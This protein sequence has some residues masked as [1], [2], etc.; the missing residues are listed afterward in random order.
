MSAG[1][2]LSLGKFML[3]GKC[4]YVLKPKRLRSEP[5]LLRAPPGAPPK[6]LTRLQIKIICAMHLPKAGQL[7][8]ERE[9]WQIDGCPLIREH[10]LSAAAV[11][12]PFLVIEAHGGSFA[13]AGADLDECS[14]GNI[15]VSKTVPRNGLAPSWMQT[16]EVGVSD[17]D[18]AVLRCTL[19]DRT[20]AAGTTAASERLLCFTTLPIAALRTGYRNVPLRDR[21]GCKIAFCRML[22]HVRQ[23]HTHPPRLAQPS[24]DVAP[25]GRGAARLRTLVDSVVA[26]GRFTRA[27]EQRANSRLQAGAQAQAKLAC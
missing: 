7:R 3:N 22:W 6:K 19:W 20:A 12:N 9:D 16:V 18:L 27:G 5:D 17:P 21:N 25:H 24:S 15:W 4:G 1:L 11:V 23:S 8:M 26:A 10:E 13:A 2:Q 14:H